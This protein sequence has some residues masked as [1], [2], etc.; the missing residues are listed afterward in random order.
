MAPL[1]LQGPLTSS[2][3]LQQDEKLPAKP[4]EPLPKLQG[5][6]QGLSARFQ[7]SKVLRGVKPGGQA[8]TISSQAPEAP[9]LSIWGLQ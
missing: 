1:W 7:G 3:G 9:Q 6:V 5:T 2:K 4:Q 8:K